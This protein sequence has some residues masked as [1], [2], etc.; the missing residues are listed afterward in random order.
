MTHLVPGRLAQPQPPA[1]PQPLDGRRGG[2]PG[3]LGAA[4]QAPYG[5]I[6]EGGRAAAAA[7]PQRPGPV[8]PPRYPGR[9]PGRVAMLNLDSARIGESAQPG[10]LF[11]LSD[12]ERPSRPGR[13]PSV[14]RRPPCR[15]RRPARRARGRS[16]ARDRSTRAPPAPLV[17]GHRHCRRVPAHGR[18]G[19]GIP[20]RRR[21]RSTP[22][23]ASANHGA[24]TA[25]IRKLYTAS[26]GRRHPLH[27]V[28]DRASVPLFEVDAHLGATITGWFPRCWCVTTRPRSKMTFHFRWH[29][30]RRNRN[31]PCPTR[32]PGMVL[33]QPPP[34]QH[35]HDHRHQTSGQGMTALRL[36]TQTARGR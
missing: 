23:I 28:P 12:A 32:P 22:Y 9:R 6:H 1:R 26:L 17:C 16:R 25:A 36:I 14:P 8:R 35:L 2:S 33:V 34:A 10:A 15:R 7:R 29:G 5:S 3:R 19:S 24:T 30:G 21:T 18:G 31:H 20:H 11:A 27:R 13:R 4:R